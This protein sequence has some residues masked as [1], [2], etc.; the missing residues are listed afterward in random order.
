MPTGFHWI[1][2][3]GKKVANILQH[4]TGDLTCAIRFSF[5]MWNNPGDA[6]RVS[7]DHGLWIRRKVVITPQHRI[8]DITCT[9]S[10][11][12]NVSNNT[13]DA[14]RISM[15]HGLWLRSHIFQHCT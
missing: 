8:R 10:F 12:F 13:G 5:N 11:S 6:N 2:V 1:T 14:Y 7:M 4:R 15:A 3:F 9:F